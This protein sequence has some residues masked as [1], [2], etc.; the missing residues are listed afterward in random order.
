MMTS[1]GRSRA[2]EGCRPSGLHSGCGAAGGHRAQLEAAGSRERVGASCGILG[3]SW[4]VGFGL[5]SSFGLRSSRELRSCSR[6]RASWAGL[7]WGLR[8]S[9]WGLRR[10]PLCLCGVM[11]AGGW[12]GVGREGGTG[13]ATELMCG[14]AGPDP[15]RA[16]HSEHHSVGGSVCLHF[17][18]TVGF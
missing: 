17:G 11:S 12:V 16:G 15:R 10:H 5:L 14:G 13:R 2:G 8:A 9:G 7:G 4:L 18:G 1:W 6:L 3:R